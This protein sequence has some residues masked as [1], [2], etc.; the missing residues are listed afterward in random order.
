MTEVGRQAQ[1]EIAAIVGRVTARTEAAY[2][3]APADVTSP[4]DPTSDITEAARRE[5]MARLRALAYV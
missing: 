3:P 5:Q 2:R 1:R 4:T